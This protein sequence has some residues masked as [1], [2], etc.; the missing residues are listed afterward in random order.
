M[1]IY[2]A[3][4][5]RRSKNIGIEPIVVSE[6]KL[7]DVQR[8]IFAADLV[9]AAHNPAFEN[10]PEAFDSLSVDR[11]DNVLA[12]TVIDALMRVVGQPVVAGVL[13]GAE[14]ANLGRNGLANE[15]L[16]ADSADAADNAGD[17]VTL[18][19]HCAHN[20][21]FAGCDRTGLTAIPATLTFVPV[22]VFSADE[23]FIDLDNAAKLGFRL[24]QGSANF[25]AHAPSC[26]VAA[27]PHKTHDLQCTHTLFAGQ[28][29]VCDLEPI[30]KRLV[31]VFED[32]AC[33]ARKPIA[34]LCTG[35]ALPMEARSEGIDLQIATAGAVNAVRPPTGD[36]I[37][38]AMG[39]IREHILELGAG[40]LVNWCRS[41]HGDTSF[42]GGYNHV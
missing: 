28:H 41:G 26:F 10:A 22:L 33:D 12:F 29:E 23:S 1:K 42:V 5:N 35:F 7:R 8:Q 24:N 4:L 13:I 11:T 18:A 14:Q 25:V 20:R 31:R 17:H 36:Q 9:I 16:K 37:G 21:D 38:P 27:K 19:L 39:L 6:L 30:P 15:I 40:E 34:V 32:G 3:S 2:S